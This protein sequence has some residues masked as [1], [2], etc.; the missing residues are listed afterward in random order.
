M[1]FLGLASITW[2]KTWIVSG[3][4][5]ETLSKDQLNKIIHNLAHAMWKWKL[6]LFTYFMVLSFHSLYFTFTIHHKAERTGTVHLI[7]CLRNQ[8]TER[9]VVKYTRA[10]HKLF[11]RK[12]RILEEIITQIYTQ[13]NGG[14]E[15]SNDLLKFI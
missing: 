3:C 5:E 13:G 4:F 15:M 9:E 1:E 6:V 11:N 14:H 7:L 2:T 10:S 12:I 8:D